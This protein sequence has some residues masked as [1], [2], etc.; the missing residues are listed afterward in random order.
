M[1]ENAIGMRH[2]CASYNGLAGGCVVW[3]CGKSGNGLLSSALA[4][5]FIFFHAASCI[6]REDQWN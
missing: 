3:V 5:L 2:S 4:N 1:P 6:F